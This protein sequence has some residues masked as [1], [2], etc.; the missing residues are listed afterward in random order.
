M[1]EEAVME[2]ELRLK[3]GIVVDLYSQVSKEFLLAEER[4]E[5]LA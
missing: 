1:A 5:Y 3:D 2:G 4:C